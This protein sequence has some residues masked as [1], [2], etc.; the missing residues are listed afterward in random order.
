MTNLPKVSVEAAFAKFSEG[1]AELLE[2]LQLAPERVVDSFTEA[3]DFE[4]EFGEVV[5]KIQN[6]ETEFLYNFRNK[7]KKV[8]Y[9]VF[10]K[11]AGYHERGHFCKVEYFSEG[12]DVLIYD[13]ITYGSGAGAEFYTWEQFKDAMVVIPERMHD[14]AEELN[15]HGFDTSSFAQELVERFG[16]I[17]DEMIKL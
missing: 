5:A 14:L 8:G 10:K 12:C 17:Q 7:H 16:R 6:M 1:A 15:H 9:V 3:Y 2:A 13:L 11:D 4:D